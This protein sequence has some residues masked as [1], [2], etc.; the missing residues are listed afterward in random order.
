MART[1]PLRGPDASEQALDALAEAGRLKEFRVLHFATHGQMDPDAASRSAL[2]LAGDW[3]PDAAEQVKQG[4]KFHTGRLTVTAVRA[5][6]LDA[7]LVTLSACE[8][9][10]G[11]EGASSWRLVSLL[12]SDKLSPPPQKDSSGDFLWFPEDIERARAAL[13]IDRRRKA[14]AGK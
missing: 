1:I 4:K 7:D 6:K 3:L 12:R 11:R 10:L 13:L 8:T 9:G 14:H 2:L 5:W